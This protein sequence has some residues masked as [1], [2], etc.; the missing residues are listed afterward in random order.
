[1]KCNKTIAVVALVTAT[2]TA[3]GDLTQ[4]TRDGAALESIAQNNPALFRTKSASVGASLQTV[5]ARLN[6]F[7]AECFSGTGIGVTSRTGTSTINFDARVETIGGVT[8]F[9]VLQEM[10]S[11]FAHISE[12]TKGFNVFSSTQIASNGGGTNLTTTENKIVRSQHDV[13][14]AHASGQATG[15]PDMTRYVPGL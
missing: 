11:G 14:V 4:S 5:T 3:C 6:N 9:V 7:A 8:R 15:C 12:A 10:A 13:I 1:M 2:L